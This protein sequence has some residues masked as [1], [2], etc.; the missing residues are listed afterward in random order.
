MPSTWNVSCPAPRLPVPESTATWQ[1]DNRRSARRRSKRPSSRFA[2]WLARSRSSP[3]A[4]WRR[5]SIYAAF[6]QRMV[7][8]LAAVGG[9]IWILGEGRKPQLAYQ[10]N[11]SAEAAGQKNRK[12]RRKHFRCST[13]SL[14]AS[15]RSSCRRFVSAGDERLGGNPTRQLLVIHPLGARQPGRRPDR[16]LPAG[17][18]AAR[19]RSA[20]ICSSSSRC[21]SC[22]PSGSR[23]ASSA[24]SATG[25]RCGPRP[26]N[27][28]G[29]VHESLDV[30]ETCYTIVNEGRR[31]LGCDRV[32]RRH[33]EGRQVRDRSGQRSGHARQP[34]ATW[35]RCWASWRRAS[36]SR[37]SRSGTAGSTEDLPPQIEKAIEEYVDQSYTKSLAV[38]PLRKPQAADANQQPTVARHRRASRRT[39]ARSSGP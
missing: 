8:A 6:L 19:T 34:L 9:A 2:A 11:L 1:P 18:H 4:I 13:T 39:R 32:T 27:S 23:T 20:A 36:S 16:D 37:A 35:S 12:R 30:R 7:Q 17:R 38:I 5:K 15:R 29:P 26:I 21:A 31:L 33:S 25:I 10:I 14:P 24:T 3:R 22:R 28:R